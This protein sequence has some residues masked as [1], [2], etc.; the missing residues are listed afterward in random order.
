MWSHA[1]SEVG[2]RLWEPIKIRSLKT[3][4]RQ[5]TNWETCIHEKLVELQFRT[6]GIW[7]TLFLDILPYPCSKAMSKRNWTRVKYWRKTLFKTIAIEERDYCNRRDR[8]NSSPLKQNRRVL[9]HSSELAEKYYRT[10]ECKVEQMMR[11]MCL[12]VDT[13]LVRLISSQ[14]DWEIRILSFF[15]TTFQRDGLYIFKKDFPGL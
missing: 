6:V 7:D 9:E 1:H 2:V 10:L 5:I 8:L 14:R 13:D 15:M 12:L 11:T 3:N 4:Q